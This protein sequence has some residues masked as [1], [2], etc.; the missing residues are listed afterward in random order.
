MRSRDAVSARALGW[1]LLVTVSFA[2]TR[3]TPTPGEGEVRDGGAPDQATTADAFERVIDPDATRDAA[4]PDAAS[5]D[6]AP[7]D[8]APPG[9]DAGCD[10]EPETCDGE[11][12]D[13]DGRSDEG[14]GVG[15]PCAVGTGLCAAPGQVVCADGAA[16]CAGQAGVALVEVCNGEDDDC[17]G[18]VDEALSSEPCYSGPAGTD[19]VGACRS[20]ET[21]CVGG[22]SVCVDQARPG[23]ERCDGADR[24]CDGAVD[25]GCARCGDGEL[26]PGEA[27]DDG[28][29]EDGDGCAAWCA[30]EARGG[31]I[32]GVQHDVAIA[33]ITARGFRACY[34]G[35]YEVGGVPLDD[36]LAGC[37]GTQLLIGCR[38]TGADTLTVAAE[39]LFEEVTRDVGGG[40]GAVNPHNGVDFYFSRSASW[41]FAPAGGGVNRNTCDVVDEESPDRM[42]W[43]TQRDA[44]RGGWRC[45]ADTR[46]N[47]S[48]AF[49]RLAFTR[50]EV[51]LGPLRAFGHHGDCDSFNGC[52]D[53]ATCAEAACEHTG[54]GRPV[55][56]RE[57]R[58]LDVPDLDCDLFSSVPDV[59]DTEWVAGCNIPVV[60]D[61]VCAGGDPPACGDGRL[62][63]G[64]ACDDGNDAAGD[65]CSARCVVEVPL[66]GFDGVREG[67]AIGDLVLGGFAVCH[68]ESYDTVFDTGAVRAACPGE[69]W[70]VGCR[71]RGGGDVLTVAAVGERATIFDAVPN[72]AGAFREHNG[73]R[74]YYGE[75]FSFGFAPAG[76]AVNRRPCDT[77]EDRGALR[78]CWHTIQRGGWRCGATTGLNDS[79]DW[80]RVVMSARGL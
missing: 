72:E 50:T 11:D 40:A 28:N 37:A 67:V 64:E 34:T 9:D 46:L 66:E 38:P 70:V 73:A 32:A 31:L 49:E 6:A 56:W 16:V 59:L 47:G 7:G 57:G 79:G 77:A 13:C 19:G 22:G 10:P 42:C 52:V 14:F 80:E 33:A 25:E 15:A 4:A 3:A 63:A 30:L 2:C 60:F 58:C 21:A 54:R 12:E 78:L 29:R 62:D 41:G 20:G 1:V 44:F 45:G 55:S 61:V 8:G 5:R 75:D 71:P 53:A 69:T 74:W 51:A 76:A 36:V 43:H 35:L 24:D 65:G 18:Q 68:T 27:C 26:D 39:G 48:R 17:D 23:E